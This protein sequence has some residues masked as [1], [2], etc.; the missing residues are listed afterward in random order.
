V[1][2]RIVADKRA[3]VARRKV[4]RPL[5]AS[6]M[7]RSDRSLERALARAHTGFIMECKRRSP[8]QGVLATS[9]DPVAVA[10]SY[11]PFAD[12]VSVLTDEP[13]FGGT[14]EHLAAVR[15]AVTQPVLCKDFI[16]DPYQ[17][18]EARLFGADAV[19]LMASVLD[20]ASL[21][22]CLALCRD[23][24]LDALVEVHDAD[25][26]ER[27]LALEAPIVGINNRN[28][29]TLEVDLGVSERL[30]SRVPRDRLC[31]A[32]SG[33]GGH[34]DVRRLR[35]E[36]DAFLVGTSL[37][38]APEASASNVA[39]A[40]AVREL[41]FG[42]VKI[43]GLT[44]ASDAHAA[45]AAGAIFGGVVLWPGSPRAVTLTQAA[46]VTEGVDLCWVGVFVDEDRAAVVEAAR[47]LRLSVV[48]LH[49][50]EDAGYVAA[51]AAE[52]PECELWKAV[53]VAG[54]AV[55]RRRADSG[56]H[57][58]LFDARVPGKVGGTGTRFDWQALRDHPERGD[59]VLSGG[60]EADCAAEAD[61][62]GAWALDLASGVEAAPG[63]KDAA[64]LGALFAALRGF[65]RAG[66]PR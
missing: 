32:E 34:R 24:A 22:G 39:R 65:G 42:R 51:L 48:Q 11:A 9:Y 29:R 20:Q 47:R 55:D 36:V 57:R 62:I 41:L 16:V 2:E 27:A 56:A 18:V 46:E 28:L 61:A 8:S 53:Q 17:I 4:E 44:R 66:A 58:L 38:H 59:I 35:A 14:L 10:A 23:L 30:A 49:G 21:A 31:V 52:L 37:M 15:A 54:A 25:E 33:I 63:I 45:R 43:C 5:S 3:A 7:P 1:L 40:D 50:S 13:Y 19:L 60:I 26:L 6:G 64:K 12:A